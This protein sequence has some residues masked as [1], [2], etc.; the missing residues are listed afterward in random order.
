MG[1]LITVVGG[2]LAGWQLGVMLAKLRH[3]EPISWLELTATALAAAVIWII[4]LRA[5]LP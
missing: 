2:G 3:A 5:V 4:L 1:T